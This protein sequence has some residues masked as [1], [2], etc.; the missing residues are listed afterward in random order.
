VDDTLANLQL[1][2]QLLTD[3]GYRARAVLTG[4]LALQ[5]VQSEPPDL[6]LLDVNMPQMNGYEVCERLKANPAWADI[7]VLFISALN[8]TLDKV[9]A[10]GVG[11][12]DYVIKPFQFEEVEARVATHLAMRRQKRALQ[13]SYQRLQELEKL[14]DDLVHLVVHDMRSPLCALGT[15][16]EILGQER[17]PAALSQMIPVMSHSV[18]LL[19]GMVDSLLDLSKMEAG[20]MKLEV[21]EHEV[22]SLVR[23][24]MQP[25]GALQQNQQLRLL[26]PATDL[27]LR[28]DAELLVRVVQNLLGNALKFTPDGS[29]IR[30]AWGA[31]GE[32]VRLTVTDTGRGIPSE[33]HRTIFE[34]FGRVPVG[35]QLRKHSTG[36]GLYFCKMVVEA[37]GGRIG[38]ES[39][40][41]QGST[42]WLE[43]PRCGP[44]PGPGAA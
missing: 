32:V 42:F 17:S 27:Q 41:G 35:G 29:P 15:A 24:A 23:D 1:L 34:K 43:L 14:R 20:K 13:D 5:A 36:L 7:P 18:S 2:A 26:P 9:K 21:A 39:Q 44:P 4:V 10:F 33:F 40:V 16:V 25:L 37:H 28:G 31:Q 38:V 3:R 6:I 12:V 30:V 19:T 22:G 8:E 11:G